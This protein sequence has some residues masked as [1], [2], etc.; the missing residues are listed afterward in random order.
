MND[1][2][3]KELSKRIENAGSVRKFAKEIGMS[4][5]YVSLVM[6]KKAEPAGRILEALG[7]EKTTE[8]KKVK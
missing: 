4:S 6:N 2:V 3:L 7:F 5:A 8:I 1:V